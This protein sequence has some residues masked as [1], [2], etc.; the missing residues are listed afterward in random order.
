M[1]GT[2]VLKDPNTPSSARGDGGMYVCT[3]GNGV[4]QDKTAEV[5]V[6]VQ[7]K[8]ISQGLSWERGRDDHHLARGCKLRSLIFSNLVFGTERQCFYQS[9]YLV[10]LHWKK[11][12]RH[13]V[14]ILC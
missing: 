7:C 8:S 1:Q 11:I 6:T 2:A 13:N 10:G 3:V 5:Y 4:G 12:K 9:S 14:V